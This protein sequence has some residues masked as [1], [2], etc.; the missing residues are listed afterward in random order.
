MKIQVNALFRAWDDPAR[1]V[2]APV[3]KLIQW[4]LPVELSRTAPPGPGSQD[5][6]R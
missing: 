3:E 2:E 1:E 5:R 4:A 6:P